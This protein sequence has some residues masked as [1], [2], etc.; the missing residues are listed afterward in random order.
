[1]PKVF[2]T[3]AI[4][5]NASALDGK[6]PNFYAVVLMSP[7]RGGAVAKVDAKAAIVL[8]P[9]QNGFGAS[10]GVAI[11]AKSY[12]Q[13]KKALDDLKIDWAF[14]PTS[15]WSNDTVTQAL[16]TAL[17]SEDGFTYY[18]K[19]DARAV[20]AKLTA[21]YTAPYLAHA[22]M[23]PMNATVSLVGKGADR[24]ATV[25]VGTQVPALSQAAAA[26]VLGIAKENVTLKVPFLGGGFGRRLEV[27]IVA[28]AASI[29][30]SH[31][32]ADG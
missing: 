13:A 1:M 9:N 17:D 2:A 23:E 10:G 26:K 14:S 16:S 30:L 12:W 18:S 32:G 15:A 24:K 21:T 3:M 11:V 19:G 22:T 25:W 31:F 20:L 27:D 29:A 5:A 7:Q 4:G 28:Q 6:I 8:P